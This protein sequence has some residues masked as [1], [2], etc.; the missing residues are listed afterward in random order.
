MPRERI[1]TLVSSWRDGRIDRRELLTRA[2]ALGVS[3][4]TVSRL[5]AAPVSA[6]DTAGGVLQIGRESE[7]QPL[8]NP[9]KGSTGTQIQVFDLT[10]S[11]L[12]KAND[13][14]ELVPDLAES[15]EISEDASQFT[16][17]L[18]EGLA[19]TDGEPLTIDDVI[20]TY[21]LGMTQAAA[22]RQ[23]VKLQ[24]IEGAQAFYDGTATEVPG[25][26]R[27]DDRTLRI[28]LAQPNIAF[29]YAT[30][31]TNSLMWILPEHIL[32][33]ADPATLDTHPYIQNPTVGSGPF[34][35]VEYVQ[36]Q[37]IQFEANPNFHLGAPKI[38]QVFINLAVPAT[39][40][41]QL[42]SG[43]LHLMP[44]VAPKEADRLKDNETLTMTSAPGIGVFQIAIN[45]ERF[46][47]KRFRQALMYAV[48]RQALLDVVLLGQG[49]I[50][51]STIIGPEWATF[52]DLNPYPYDPDR[53]RA[54]LDEAG[55]DTERTIELTWS[56]GFTNIEL[57]APV[58]QQ[59]L[60]EVGV[61]IELAPLETAAYLK[62]VVEEP[63]MDMAWFGGG[64][65]RLDP[66]VSSPY[67][68][69]ST[70]TP[71]G[72]NTTHFCNEELDELFLAGRGTPDTT[73]RAEIY[74]Q[75]AQILN[76]EVPTFFWWS[77]NIVWGT[78]N[79]LQGVKPG[80]NQYIQ[81]NIHEWTL[82]E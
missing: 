35:F 16:F 26:E 28:T 21:K 77:D 2:A 15:F 79:K 11:R 3:A 51:N 80:P 60:A 13:Q 29:L 18:R 37:Y 9:L 19:W 25:L 75:A 78:S 63:D 4:A 32:A 30:A 24:Q 38:G 76:E 20:F 36:D 66:D 59:Q 42:E 68:L 23:W 44:R 81:W 47:D 45:N 33:D 1:E 31:F 52:D 56:Q 22:A 40:L 6:Q 41:A 27:V 64:S 69:C 50:V 46:P 5:T 43:E 14:L 8:W 54:L 82:G 48:D 72:A 65:Y 7:V 53:A 70:W 71:A 62:K 61:K 58:F 17:V 34:T 12:L 67:Y 49:E 57:A 39:Q 74:H 55:W 10:F 73:R